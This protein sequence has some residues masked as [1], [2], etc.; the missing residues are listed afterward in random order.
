MGSLTSTLL[1]GCTCRLLCFLVRFTSSGH[2]RLISQVGCPLFICSDLT[3]GPLQGHSTDHVLILRLEDKLLIGL[4]LLNRQYGRILRSHDSLIILQDAC[5]ISPRANINCHIINILRIILR[6][7]VFP[8][9]TRIEN[10]LLITRLQL[11]VTVSIVCAPAC[12]DSILSSLL[13]PLHVLLDL[14]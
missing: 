12:S 11:N 4:V 10:K 3:N 2:K 8:V 7:T 5:I 6:L 9:T 14:L 13:L 1:V